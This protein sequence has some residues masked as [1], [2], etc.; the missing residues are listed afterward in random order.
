[1]P[2]GLTNALAAFMDL[3]HRVF[4]PY[5][6][7]FVVVFIDDILVTGL[8]IKEMR[9]LEEVSVWNPRLESRKVIL[10]NIVMKFTLLE[11]IKETQEKDP[12]V[13]EWLEKVKKGEK[14]DFN[15]GINSILR[16]RNRIVVPKDE[17]LKKETLE[18]AQRSKFTVKTELQR[19]SG[20]LQ[21]LEIPEWKWENITMDFVSELPTTQ[22]GHDAIWNREKKQREKEELKGTREGNGE[23]AQPEQE[24]EKQA[25]EELRKPERRVSARA[26]R[27][28]EIGGVSFGGFER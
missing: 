28:L 8:I 14:S 9:L 18:E 12:E 4:K 3:M 13:Q 22:K 25:A 24:K 1:M 20:L 17:G 21:P 23:S 11:C 5:L 27:N 10:G 15:L 2:F 6:D 19:P 7:Q 26:E 16:F